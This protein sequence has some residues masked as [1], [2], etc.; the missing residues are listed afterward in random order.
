MHARV[1]FICES[2]FSKERIDS[3]AESELIE[4]DYVVTTEYGVHSLETG[5]DRSIF[6]RLSH[7]A[8]SARP[9]HVEVILHGHTGCGGIKRD[10][11]APDSSDAYSAEGLDAME[12]QRSQMAVR[13]LI[14]DE[15]GI[16]VDMDDMPVFVGSSMEL[17]EIPTIGIYEDVFASV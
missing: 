11:F 14:L 9:T 8:D 7:F 15:C 6:D 12:V 1:L 4:A 13:D 16:E 2:C 3:Y 17:A 10:T 5:D